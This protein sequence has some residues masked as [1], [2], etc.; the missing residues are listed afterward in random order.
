MW[1]YP[2]VRVEFWA[3][4][5]SFVGAQ[6]IAKAMKVDAI[7]RE[8]CLGRAGKQS[9]GKRTEQ[10]LGITLCPVLYHIFSPS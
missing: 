1:R 2:A 6:L 7:I 3:M 9:K 4:G 10:G 5:L 8:I